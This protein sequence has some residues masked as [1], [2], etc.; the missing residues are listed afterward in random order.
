M[1][2][3][4]ELNR[5]IQLMPCSFWLV[6]FLGASPSKEIKE[7]PPLIW[8]K[9]ELRGGCICSH[10]EKRKELTSAFKTIELFSP[11][12]GFLSILIEPCRGF[13]GLWGV[14]FSVLLCRH[15]RRKE[16]RVAVAMRGT[17]TKQVDTI[18]TSSH[19]PCCHSMVK[20]CFHVSM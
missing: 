10:Y 8:F 5:S 17:G 16:G 20:V 15:D 13:S 18:P 7:K 6:C 2:E 14:L 11:L 4:P 9:E 1:Q 3:S 19:A 12:K